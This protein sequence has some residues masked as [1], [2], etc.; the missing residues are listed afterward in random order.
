MTPERWQR[1]KELFE[2]AMDRE[3]AE[4]PAFLQE[5]CAGD[6]AL[7]EEIESLVVEQ[8]LA[9]DF[10]KN[11]VM[12]FHSTLAGKKI[13]QYKVMEKIGEGGM[14]VVYRAFDTN[15][16]RFV[17]LK[18]LPAEMMLDPTGK[19]RFVQEAR[20]VSALNH[21]NII[22]VHDIVS[23]NGID[24]I[25]MEYV[26]GKT[27]DQLI[28]HKGL[29]VI[30]TLNYALQIADALNRAHS[31]RIVHRDLKPSNI[32]VTKD[33]FVKVLDFGLAKLIEQ[34]R[35]TEFASGG[36]TGSN[37]IAGTV[38]YMSPEQAQ[39]R[40]TDARSDIFSFG[41]VLYEMI[42]GVRAFR[43]HDRLSILAALAR[44]EPQKI[45]ELVPSTPIEL[46]RLI[47]RALSKD[48][49]R[50]WP[51]MAE[52][53]KA[54]ADIR[55]ESLVHQKGSYRRAPQFRKG[56]PQ[57]IAA[58]ISSLKQQRFAIV[59]STLLTVG[60]ISTYVLRLST[61]RLIL[62]RPAATGIPA[63][64]VDDSNLPVAKIHLRGNLPSASV[65]L[66]ND[67]SGEMRDGKYAFDVFSLGPHKLR[68]LYDGKE[69][70]LAFDIHSK[71]G[72]PSV[73][74]VTGD[75]P[76]VLVI[77]SYG[78]TIRVRSTFRSLDVSLDKT[79]P[80]NVPSVG[81]Q[82]D[83]QVIGSHQIAFND[84]NGVQTLTF[85]TRPTPTLNIL[86]ASN[87]D[88]GTLVLRANMDGVRVF[89]NGAE[90]N[91][92]RGVWAKDL[93]SKRYIV[94]VMK[95]GYVP[96]PPKNIEIRTKQ[97]TDE[98]FFLQRQTQS[99]MIIIKGG[100]PDAQVSID[101]DRRGV[102]DANGYYE[103]SGLVPGNHIV[104]ISKEQYL[105]ST[106]SIS[107]TGGQ[108]FTLEG[109]DV[110]LVQ[111]F[112]WLVVRALPANAQI[113][114]QKAHGDRLLHEVYNNIKIQVPTGSYIVVAS[115]GDAV[116]TRTVH[117]DSGTEKLVEFNLGPL[118]SSPH[119]RNESYPQIVVEKPVLSMKSTYAYLTDPATWQLVN[120]WWIHHGKDYEWIRTVRGTNKLLCDFLLP[121]SMFGTGRARWVINFRNT[122]NQV[123]YE[124]DG[125]V[126]ARSV[127]VEG[128]KDRRTTP[129]K[130][131]RARQY[132]I[133][134]TIQ[135]GRIVHRDEQDEILD[136]LQEPGVDFT[137][138]KMGFAGEMGLV[139]NELSPK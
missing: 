113:A 66:D 83:N 22:T 48:P 36:T 134:I 123:I 63:M 91:P 133:E 78:S 127:V 56:L 77:A 64:S 70:E 7:R 111:S 59:L 11:P 3:P 39:G 67:K 57:A 27:L 86:V 101:D 84:G 80:R 75:G 46:E 34:D 53:K 24:F 104:K 18:M 29:P 136:E 14:G 41:A 2:E 130:M 118:A 103:L 54:M 19:R 74:P 102:V 117:V 119:T 13:L 10:M 5:V 30:D 52:L 128:K 9:G 85:E 8:E 62:G 50:R 4:R 97:R 55:E 109:K 120:G 73:G 98:Y 88:I 6:E 112:G 26:L 65:F 99:A 107:V 33:G 116:D 135:P 68:L 126:F 137:V 61:L 45:S 93:P 51:S 31:A 76:P 114:Y 82:M 28:G 139:V 12:H 90:Q 96:L 69:L 43:G 17:A 44:D 81:L 110:R 100:L 47:L 1:V 131:G 42:T 129:H 35:R 105:P 138:G 16:G 20:S 115:A 106:V 94:R 40:R 49:E 125:A 23:E 38:A 132:R 89:L 72:P 21:P 95:E 58:R 124:L 108:V 25:V 60:A 32:M 121:R 15:L 79:S 122:K 87:R 37:T 71:D 92:I